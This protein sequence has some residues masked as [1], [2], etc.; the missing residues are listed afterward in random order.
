MDPQ[1]TGARAGRRRLIAVIGTAALALP[2]GV[3]VSNA[4][5]ADVS[6]GATTAPIQE[7]QTTPEPPAQGERPDGRDCPEKDGAGS[8]DSG[9]STAPSTSPEAEQ[10]AL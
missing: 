7:S 9:Q 3:L 6:G 2:G 5:A 10:T 1:D 8:G 4:L